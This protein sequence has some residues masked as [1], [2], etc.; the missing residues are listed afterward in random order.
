ML[1]RSRKLT[2]TAR[3][4]PGSAAGLWAPAACHRAQSGR[5]ACRRARLEEHPIHSLVSDKLVTREYRTEDAFPAADVHVAAFYRG[6][7]GAPVL[8]FDRIV[9]LQVCL[10]YL[11]PVTCGPELH[12]CGCRL[13]VGAEVMARQDTKRSTGSA[14]RSEQ[15]CQLRR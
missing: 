8:R 12:L 4:A 1:A 11:R 14:P 5:G 13:R 3:Q 15:V 2:A 6:N 9:A 7:I 10:A